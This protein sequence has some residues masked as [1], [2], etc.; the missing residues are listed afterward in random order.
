MITLKSVESIVKA[1]IL[2]QQQDINTISV[3][4]HH[5]SIDIYANDSQ[6]RICV[7]YSKMG[8]K[9]CLFVSVAN[10]GAIEY[11]SDDAVISF[12]NPLGPFSTIAKDIK[13]LHNNYRNRIFAE[14]IKKNILDIATVEFDKQVLESK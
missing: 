5:K 13:L 7:S 3:S 10:N 4:W 11:G 8:F 2:K 9:L 6:C 12:I 14:M 1:M